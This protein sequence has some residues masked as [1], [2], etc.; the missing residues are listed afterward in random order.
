L[1]RI[2]PPS[3]NG[4]RAAGRSPLCRGRYGC[5]V[6]LSQCF[7]QAIAENSTPAMPLSP[8]YSRVTIGGARSPVWASLRVRKYHG[9]SKAA[10]SVFMVQRGPSG[11]VSWYATSLTPTP[12]TLVK[13]VPGPLWGCRR[14]T[15]QRACGAL[16]RRFSQRPPAHRTALTA[17]ESCAMRASRIRPDADGVLPRRSYSAM[18][19]CSS[20]SVSSMSAALTLWVRV[21]EPVLSLPCCR[22]YLHITPTRK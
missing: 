17:G 16:L 6:E 8:H 22:P 9:G 7:W 12:T 15:S 11:R 3:T 1:R 10:W 20:A 14:A 18:S 19:A 4:L 2:A 5:P 21:H 13:R